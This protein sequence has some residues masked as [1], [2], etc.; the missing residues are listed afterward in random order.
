M[1]SW[2]Y[3]PVFSQTSNRLTMRANRIA[4]QAPRPSVHRYSVLKVRLVWVF[5]RAVMG[6][7]SAGNKGIAFNRR[8]VWLYSVR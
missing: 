6:R 3:V 1:F 7:D 5:I 2:R 8:G 4:K